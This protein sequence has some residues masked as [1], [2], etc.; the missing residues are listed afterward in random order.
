MRHL[1]ANYCGETVELI[2]TMYTLCNIICRICLDY[3]YHLEDVL[4]RPNN[5]LINEVNVLSHQPPV[6][7]LQT[8][9]KQYNHLQKDGKVMNMTALTQIIN[10][11]SGIDLYIFSIVIC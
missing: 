6:A 4:C 2:E 5:N 8:C 10:F 7:K 1:F 11:N 3:A 9:Q